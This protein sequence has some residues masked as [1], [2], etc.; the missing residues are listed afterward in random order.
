MFLLFF[1]YSDNTHIVLQ[2]DID[3]LLNVRTFIF[4]VPSDTKVQRKKNKHFI[5]LLHKQHLT[6]K[7]KERKGWKKQI[8][9]T[10]EK[11]KSSE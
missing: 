3:T 4:I 5:S 1:C 6:K 7:R 8:Y 2:D 9:F 11:K 10:H